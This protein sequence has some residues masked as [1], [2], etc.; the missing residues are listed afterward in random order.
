LTSGELKLIKKLTAGKIV[1]RK[2][3]TFH[4]CPDCGAE[5]RVPYTDA[6]EPEAPQASLLDLF[7]EEH[8]K[9]EEAHG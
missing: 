4:V 5:H 8:A 7:N 3:P 2:K 1:L 9:K 6:D